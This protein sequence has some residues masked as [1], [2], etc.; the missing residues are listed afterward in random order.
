MWLIISSSIA[1]ENQW[2][3]FTFPTKQVSISAMCQIGPFGSGFQSKLEGPGFGVGSR[4]L[5]A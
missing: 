4:M 1:I 3:I 2:P 5:L